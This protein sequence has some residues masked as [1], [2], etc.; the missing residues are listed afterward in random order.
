MMQAE[1]GWSAGPVEM[2]EPA[3]AAVSRAAWRDWVE[4][5]VVTGLAPA[6]GG[7]LRPED[8]F[9]L[10]GPFCWPALAVVVVGLRHGLV[11]GLGSAL[12]LG[13]GMAA[14][15][16]WTSPHAGGTFPAE[17]CFGLLV[18]AVVS[19]EFR[20]VWLRRLTQAE[21]RSEE[22]RARLERLSR[23]HHLLRT[24]HERLE[25]RL[26]IG[27]PSLGELLAIL[28][29]RLAAAGAE[30]PLRALGETL[31]GLAMGH[32]GVQAA[33]LYGLAEDGRLEVEPA[34]VLG[35]CRAGE[36]DPLVREA[37]RSGR[38]VSVRS[39]AEGAAGSRLLLAVPLVDVEGRVRGVMAVSE[40]QFISFN[41]DT[42][43]LLAVLGAH[44][45]DLLAERAPEAARDVEEKPCLER[46]HPLSRR[47]RRTANPVAAPEAP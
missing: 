22:Q 10:G 44:V 35:G 40:M 16:K 9:F 46:R 47:E 18:L 3:G 8:P 37:L 4:T 42:L 13:L 21:R 20:E 31:L 32:G 6:L 34:A 24:S 15:W 12:A 30:P 39:F 28:N 2:R 45:G 43:R 26:A 29:R 23:V 36:E 19:G 17:P 41:D 5:V 25:E 1:T 33:A 7:W 14:A 38:P 11:H 27:A